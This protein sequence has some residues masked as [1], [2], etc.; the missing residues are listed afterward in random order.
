[1]AELYRWAANFD[2]FEPFRK[3]LDLIGYAETAY[4][5]ELA[6]ADWKAPASGLGYMEL[7]KLADALT[8]YANRPQ[9]VERWIME[10]LE[11]EGEAG[12]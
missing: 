8:E 4:G 1:V 10:L 3:Y 9:E 6:L 7:A 5:E 2:N 11:V 12:L